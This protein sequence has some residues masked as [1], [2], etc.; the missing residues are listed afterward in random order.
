[1]EVK[2]FVN[3]QNFLIYT[4]KQVDGGKDFCERTKLSRLYKKAS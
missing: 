3:G 4:K 2:I 1:M